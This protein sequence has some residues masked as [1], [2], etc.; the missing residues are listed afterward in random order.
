MIVSPDLLLDPIEVG[1]LL[2]LA[3]HCLG[4]GEHI[5][6]MSSKVIARHLSLSCLDEG[7][8]VAGHREKGELETS[9]RQVGEV[10]GGG[11]Q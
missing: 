9:T 7:K 3:C 6:E 8:Q 11:W 10:G 2:S 1:V 4:E 5:L